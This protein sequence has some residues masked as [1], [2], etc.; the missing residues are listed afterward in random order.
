MTLSELKELWREI[1]FRPN[2]KMG[3]NFLVDNN[4]RDNIVRALGLNKNSVVMEIGAGFGIMST[5]IA[6]G[7]GKLYAVE[8]DRIIAGLMR[9]VLKDKKNI[10]L[11]EGDALEVD[12]ARLEPG[13]GKLVVFGNIPYYITTPVIEKIIDS[14]KYISRAFIMVQEEFAD[15]LVSPPGSRIYGSI[16]CFVQFHARVRK[17]FKISRNSFYPRPKVDSCLL[18]MVILEE[19]SVKVRDEKLMFSIIRKAFS[20]RR[21]QLFNTLSHGDFLSIE[22]K[23]WHDLLLRCNI[24]PTRRP[25]EL[26]L[27]DFAAISDGAGDIMGK[28]CFKSQD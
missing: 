22:R 26:S 5:A 3:Q 11:V 6:D 8:K 4:V 9:D 15:R 24:D 13:R 18:E 12:I 10:V 14:K 27:S 7:C 16:S 21:K 23:K 20:Q 28:A 17:L 19:P 25:E 2:K 1:D